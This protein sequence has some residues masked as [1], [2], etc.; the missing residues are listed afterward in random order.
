MA[1]LSKVGC[2]AGTCHGN[3]NGKGGFKLSLRGEDPAADFAALTHGLAG[4]RVNPL[5]PAESLILLKPTMSLAHQGGRRFTRDSVEYQTMFAWIAA[6]A[7]DDPTASELVEL[8][9]AP[10]EQVLYEPQ[11]EIRLSVT[12][13][14]A[15]GARRDV[16]RMAVYEPSQPIVTISPD[17]VAT[18]NRFGETTVLVRYLNRQAAVRLTFVPNRANFVWTRPAAFNRFDGPVLEKLHVLRVLPTDVCDDPTFVR[19]VFIDLIGLLPTADEARSFVA[20]SQPDKR[21]RMVDRLLARR[22]FADHWAMKWAD[23][24][25]VEE[26]QLDRTGVRVFHDWIRDNIA[27]GRPLDEFAGEIL[28]ARGSTYKTAPAN[29]WRAL[30][31]PLSRG[32][33]VA[34]V[35]LGTR[36]QCAKCHNHPFERW[37]QEEYFQWAAL[38]A[39]I[40]YKIIKNERRDDLDKHEFN[41]EQIVLYSDKGEVPLPTR[42]GD[43]A[44][45]KF[46]GE[47][48]APGP[49]V[50]GQDRLTPLARWLTRPEHPQFARVQANRIWGQLLGRGLVDPIDD[51]RANNPPSHPDLLKMLAAELV[52]SRFDLRHIIRNVVG[53]RTYQL[54]AGDGES[55]AADYAAAIVARHTAEQL[56]DAIYHVTGG[57]PEFAEYPPGIRAGQLPGVRA[58]TTRR[59]GTRPTSDDRFLTTF[60]KPER[61]LVCDCERSNGT[62]L[63]QTFSLVGGPVIE[64]ALSKTNPRLAAWANPSLNP[65]RVIDDLYWTAL[66]RPPTADELARCVDLLRNE[67]NR[68]AALQDIAWAVVNSKEFLFRH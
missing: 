66:T 34:Q 55:Q 64:R 24:L 30:R 53:S 44:K 32:E 12:A 29:F 61:L 54:S 10:G 26:K 21:G 47:S 36:L 49:G 60:G 63:A 19:R 3:Q 37:T 2:N 67:P 51:F 20:D 15:G 41:G 62:T 38:F 6:G 8:E 40:D 9:V 35:F 33:A 23:L 42:G 5:A 31:D 18:R 39:R 46:L 57:S 58:Y 52:Q 50:N 59:R 43:P 25:R 65:E 27:R 17:G 28:S 56:L 45:P 1:V 11:S 22:E 14:F 68:A 4:R 48:A 13:K 16:T 7:G